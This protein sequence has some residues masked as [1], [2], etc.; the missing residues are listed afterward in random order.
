MRRS[1]ITALLLVALALHTLPAGAQEPTPTAPRVDGPPFQL[2]FT[3]PPGPGTWLFQQHYGNTTQAFN[4]GDVWYEFG[5]GLHFGVD[6]EAPCGTPVHAIADGVVMFVD[7]D[8]FGAGPHN[9]VLDHPG[10]GYTSLYG[11]LQNRPL[12]IKGEPVTRGQVVGVSGDPDGSCG[13]RP[14]LHLEVRSSNY[15]RAYNPLLFFDI[16]WHMLTSIGPYNTNFQQ[17]LDTPYRWMRLED[18]PEIE[19]SGNWL[20]TYARPWPPKLEVRAPVNPPPFRALDALPEDV[21]V[22]REPVSMG[23][24]NI[25]AWWQPDDSAAVYLIDAIPGQGTGVFRQPLDGSPRAFVQ[26]APPLQTSPDGSITVERLPGGMMRLTR[27]ADGAIFDVDTGGVYPAVSPDNTRLLWETVYGEIVP[28]TSNPGVVLTV[29][30]LDGGDRRRVYTG[31]GITGQWLDAH[32]LLIVQRV[33]YRAEHRVYVLDLDAPSEAEPLLLGR[34]DFLH[35]LQVAPGGEWIAFFLAFQA[36]PATNGVYVQ[37]TEAGSSPRRLPEF[38]S[39]RWRDDDSLFLL[40]YGI[41]QAAHALG[42]AE[43]ATGAFRW[44]TDPTVLP[45]RVANGEWSVSPD[46]TTIVTLNPR[47]YG[48]YALR[49][50]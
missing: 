33:E 20:N 30:A 39:Y 35:D 16:N 12:L 15:Q 42:Y 25:G 19:F 23:A 28:G 26:L 7:A 45:I 13:S 6:F 50:G 14:H 31:T 1:F 22:T 5:Q 3:E 24:W 27:L 41:D 9:L 8:G 4:Y 37:R 21:R 47:D 34:Y 10:T 43:A 49:V 48:L 40:S 32:R 2:P 17:D 18:Q 44:L 38:G 46:G 36:D 11:H 29:S